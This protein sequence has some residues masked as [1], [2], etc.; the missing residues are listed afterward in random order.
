MDT[1]DR[2]MSNSFKVSYYSSKKVWQF[3]SNYPIWPFLGSFILLILQYLFT[4][5][6]DLTAFLLFLTF[7]LFLLCVFVTRF[8]ANSILRLSENELTLTKRRKSIDYKWVNISN[9]A[10]LIPLNGAAYAGIVLVI[11]SNNSVEYII[12]DSLFFITAKS[13]AKKIGLEIEK[14][15]KGFKFSVQKSD[16][17]PRMLDKE[18]GPPNI[19]P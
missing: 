15:L 3:E 8:Y 12:I 14:H 4:Q 13:R 2:H 9:V 16:F 6:N 11:Y 5:G 17:D 18:I 7:F 19:L 10:F 1:H